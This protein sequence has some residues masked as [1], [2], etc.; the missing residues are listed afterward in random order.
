MKK[1]VV[2][3]MA[4]QRALT[5]ITYEIIEKNR[6]VNNLILMGIK[7]RGVFLAKVQVLLFPLVV[8]WAPKAWPL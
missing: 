4:M 1:E 6:G 8:A 5:R 3:S 7:T 2:D